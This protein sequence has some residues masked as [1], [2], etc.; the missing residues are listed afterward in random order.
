MALPARSKSVARLLRTVTFELGLPSLCGL[1][2]IQGGPGIAV[3]VVDH[4]VVED[5]RVAHAE[6]ADAVPVIGDDDVVL[7][8]PVD[9]KAVETADSLQGAFQRLVRILG[10]DE[11]VAAQHD[12]GD[13]G[14]ADAVGT[15][16]P[17][18]EAVVV[19]LV[20]TVADVRVLHD[21]VLKNA[22]VAQAAQAIGREVDDAI[23]LDQRVVAGHA[24]A[25]AHVSH[26]IVPDDDI[27][28]ADFDAAARVVD[29]LRR[30]PPRQRLRR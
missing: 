9:E 3:V 5:A 27:V 6:K 22:V 26:G 21:V 14:R 2:M 28:P 10:I 15:V 17:A 25:E 29:P 7:D 13:L 19:V 8:R 30:A 20:L 24:D 18:L 16:R 11:E 12:A 4:R 23:E 1:T